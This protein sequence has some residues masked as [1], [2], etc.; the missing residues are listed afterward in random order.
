MNSYFHYFALSV[1]KCLPGNAGWHLTFHHFAFIVGFAFILLCHCPV[2]MH[3]ATDGVL[4]NR[5]SIK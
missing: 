2:M 3:Y 5:N 1:P 4:L